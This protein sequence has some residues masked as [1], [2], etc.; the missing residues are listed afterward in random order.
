MRCAFVKMVQADGESMIVD[1]YRR[2]RRRQ[3]ASGLLAAASISLRVR[4]RGALRA[5]RGCV[6]RFATRDDTDLMHSH[7]ARETYASRTPGV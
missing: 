1:R 4:P 2:K 6:S 7:R 5:P 3:L